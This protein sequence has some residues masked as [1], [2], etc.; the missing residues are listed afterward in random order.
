MRC[1]TLPSAPKNKC[2]REHSSICTAF[3]IML[4]SYQVMIH[5]VERGLCKRKEYNEDQGSNLRSC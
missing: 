4:Y 1:G 5:I 3:A 2:T